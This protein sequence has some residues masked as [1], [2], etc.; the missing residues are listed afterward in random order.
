MSDFCMGFL[1][2]ALT[3]MF[4]IVSILIIDEETA[5]STCRQVTGVNCHQ[6]W[7]PIDAELYHEFDE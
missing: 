7:Q 2:G 4:I 6:V 3:F 1:I 5:R